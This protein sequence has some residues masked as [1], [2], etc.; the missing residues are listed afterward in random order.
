MEKLKLAL[1]GKKTYILAAVG[2]AAIWVDHYFGI[3]LSDTCKA[4]VDQACSIS[5]AEAI[6]ATWGILIALTVK[7]GLTR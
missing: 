7:A 6:K 2:I 5:T 3:G 1:Q 4:A